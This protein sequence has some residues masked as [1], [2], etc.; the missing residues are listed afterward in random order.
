MN[1]TLKI[2]LTGFLSTIALAV[3]LWIFGVSP[4]YIMPFALPWGMIIII[5]AM[6]RKS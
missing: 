4:A 2:G 5:G 6:K 3:L 1:R